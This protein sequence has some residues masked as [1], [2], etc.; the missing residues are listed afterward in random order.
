M[1][2]RETLFFSLL[3]IFSLG[4]NRIS[5]CRSKDTCDVCIQEPDCVWCVRPRSEIHCIH[6]S[7]VEDNLCDKKDIVNPTGQIKILQDKPFS[8]TENGEAVQIRPQKIKLKLRKGEEYSLQF[9][10]AQAENYPVDLYY[11]MDLSA[12]MED[13]RDKLAKLGDKLARTMMNITNNFRLGFGSFVDKVDLPFVSTVPQKL[14]TPCKLN[15]NGKSVI[16]VSP[17]SFKNHIS[18]TGDYRKFTEQVLQARVSGNLDSPEGGFDALMQAI[19]CKNSIGWR[20][21]ARHLIVFSTDAEFHIAGDGKLAGIVE[22]NDARC[23]MENNTYTHDLAFDYPSVSQ[24]NHVAKDNNI[25]IVFAIVNKKRVVDVYKKLS[26]SIENSN[27]GVLDER[28]ENVIK[29]VLDNY[30]KIVDSVTISSNSSSDIEVKITSTCSHPKINGCTNIHIGEIVNFTAIIK[31][32]QC[33]KGSNKHVI[34]VKPEALDE[35]I[36][37]D[38]EV[39]CDCDCS[40]QALDPQ[41]CSN[42]G[43][44]RCGVCD[45]DPGFFGK[46]CECNKKTSDSADVSLCKASKND[47][48]ICSGLGFCRCGQCQ[49]YQRSNPDEKIFGKY[50][51]CDNY[52]CK[53]VNG[54]LCSQRGSCECGGIC[55]CQAGWTGDACEC[56]D[57]DNSCVK[58][59]NNLVCNGHGNCNCGKCECFDEEV[60]YSG[61]YCDECPTCEGQRCEELRPCVECQIYKSGVFNEEE[62]QSNCT[63]FQS[64]AVDKLENSHDE[65]VKT[66]TLVDENDCTFAFQYEYVNEKNLKVTAEK[67]KICR[68]P[69]N[70]LA[71]ILGVIG[72]VLLAGV[73]L[74]LTWKVCT[75]VHD[76]QEYAKFE[77]ERQ[78]MQWHRNDNPLYRQA[79]ST[80]KNPVYRTYKLSK[81][82]SE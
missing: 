69:P 41:K 42:S 27:I 68:G 3:I 19:V 30:N 51:D 44:L 59:D 32:L 52:S 72:S 63:F 78:K 17:Y 56:P 45:C 79:T 81:T 55:K 33:T 38:L 4:E 21:Q 61:K 65:Q 58:P 7:Q 66:C 39:L 46:T 23:Y 24:I 13:H 16:C 77:N 82:R 31:P 10:Y 57:S 6:K 8:S 54:R 29:L 28:S 50:C 9:Q 60:R 76:R 11:I 5:N 48:R 18:L 64:E 15:K 40:S 62:C 35:S 43:A 36:V 47:T 74:L 12:S 49:C 34:T 37:I 73:I 53:R 22:P 71:W 25:N 26:E 67:E 70:I 2:A 20:T 80:F 1:L 75:T 14:K